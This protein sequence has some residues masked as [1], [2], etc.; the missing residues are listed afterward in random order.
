MKFLIL[1]VSLY[2]PLTAFYRV[3]KVYL[4]RKDKGNCRP[5]K[6][7]LIANSVT[8][9]R[10]I[11]LRVLANKIHLKTSQDSV[12]K[13]LKKLNYTNPYPTAISLLPEKNRLSGLEWVRE[14][15]HNNWEH[16]VFADEASIW[17]S[18]ER[19]RIIT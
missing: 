5:I 2:S 10:H 15:I 12:S 13:C 7:P 1:L 8:Q 19:I 4:L 11:S 3:G 16:T 14:N 6:T 17:I 9:Q 18:Q